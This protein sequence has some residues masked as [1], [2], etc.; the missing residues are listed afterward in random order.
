VIIYV[1]RDGQDIGNWPEE[2]FRERTFRGEIYADDYYFHEGMSDWKLVSEY[3]AAKKAV[4][5]ITSPTTLDKSLRNTTQAAK[6]RTER[7]IVLDA[8]AMLGFVGGAI[9]TLGVFAPIVRAPIFGS[10]NYFQNGKGDG[11]ILLIAGIAS[12]FFT[13]QRKFKR[14]WVTGAVSIAYALFTMGHFIY[15]MEKLKRDLA[16]KH[17]TS[18]FSGITSTMMNSV[19]LQWG[20]PL[21]IFGGLV[22]LAAAALGS[23][24]L[25]VR[26]A[27]QT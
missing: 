5:L 11:V 7:V 27:R 21:L 6:A 15:G 10:L 3:R 19:E 1:C 20:L 26:I 9:L 18:I 22:V 13:A 17:D 12:I 24:K 14:L 2:E 25:R 4:R 16:S 8:P 23:G